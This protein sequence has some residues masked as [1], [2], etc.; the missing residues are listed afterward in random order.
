MRRLTLIGLSIGILGMMALDGWFV[1]SSERLRKKQA[2]QSA[3][4]Q[5]YQQN[6]YLSAAEILQKRR[7]QLNDESSPPM[8][9]LSEIE[10]DLGT[11]YLSE[12]NALWI[13]SG[14]LEDAKIHALLNLA[15]EHLRACLMINP[16]HQDARL[17]LE[18]AWRITPPPREL[19][20]SD[21][22]GHKG[23]LFSTTPGLAGG[24]P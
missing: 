3:A 15:R 21:F 16:T 6:D 4:M 23:S 14:V 19:P 5:A 22:R 7:A 10:Y 12:A 9:M 1:L 18:Y 24:G 20:K 11:V 13:S 2:I 17:H 8:A